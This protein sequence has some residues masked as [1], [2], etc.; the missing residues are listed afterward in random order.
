MI[1]DE[2]PYDHCSYVIRKEKSVESLL[3]SDRSQSND[4]KPQVCN[5]KTNDILQKTL[6][7]KSI[8]FFLFQSASQEFNKYQKKL[9][10]SLKRKTSKKK[11]PKID[12]SDTDT[13]L[14]LYLKK[15]KEENFKKVMKENMQFK[16]ENIMYYKKKDK[17][18][19]QFERVLQ[20]EKNRAIYLKKNENK[21]MYKSKIR[22]ILNRVST[23]L[24]SASRNSSINIPDVSKDN[25]NV[26]SRLYYNLY[27]N[28]PSEI[29]TKFYL[30]HSNS[31]NEKSFS[32]SHSNLKSMNPNST[33]ERLLLQNKKRAIISYSSGPSLKKK[34]PFILNK[35]SKISLKKERKNN[36]NIYTSKNKEGNSLLH[37]YVIKNQIDLSKYVIEKNNTIVNSVNK[38]LNTPLHLAV[39]HN[40][41]DIA[42]LLVEKGAKVEIKNYLKITPIDLAH[43]LKRKSLQILLSKYYTFKKSKK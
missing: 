15:K 25:S 13:I 34:K 26:Y 10:I 41:Y 21:L 35:K 42:K 8:H 4:K 31:Q 5:H 17:K 20:N 7:D 22:A 37:E 32:L 3:K 27:K 18:N 24:V 36:L 29:K 11:E 43:K 30:N 14:Q 6:N 12:S 19:K 9:N 16:Q 2:N 1:F 33:S 28:N 40:H 39:F 38:E 23:S